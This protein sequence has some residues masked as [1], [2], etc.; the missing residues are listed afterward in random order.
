MVLN[1]HQFQ[2]LIQCIDFLVFAFIFN[3]KVQIFFQ[4]L[5]QLHILL[6]KDPLFF[7]HFGEIGLIIQINFPLKLID[8][9]D[10]VH[11]FLNYQLVLIF[12]LF[13]NILRGLTSG[14]R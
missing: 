5:F 4:I 6:H 14:L 2:L 12:I 13:C 7:V 1:S 9:I 11:Q 8:L 3:L 10:K